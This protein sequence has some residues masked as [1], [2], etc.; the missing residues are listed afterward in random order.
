MADRLN[1]GSSAGRRGRLALRWFIL[2]TL[3][4][5]TSTACGDTTGDGSTT[6]PAPT[7]TLELSTTATMTESTIT[8]AVPEPTTTVHPLTIMAIGDSITS[9]STGWATYRCY[10]NGALDDD[11]VSFDFVG[12]NSAPHRGGPYGCPTVFDE[13]HEA[14]WGAH[15]QDVVDDVTTSVGVLQP[16]VA[17]VHLG[18]NDLSHGQGPAGTA[19]ELG[20]FVA[21]LQAVSPDI[22]ILVAQIIPCDTPAVWCT[23]DLP[24]FNDAVA[25]FAG[26]STGGSSVIVVDMETG[27]DLSDLRDALHPTDAGDEIMASRWMAALQEAGVIEVS[28]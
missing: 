11:E 10:L 5:L 18:T 3:V 1:P 7:T 19:D 15:I 21:G 20:S 22:T 2:L 8:T 26:L 17:L 4:I 16:D 6:T 24:A 28:G 25:S 12:R 27:F 23:E 13:D 9:G 14:M